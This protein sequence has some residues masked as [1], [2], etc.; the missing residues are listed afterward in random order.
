M[1]IEIR[2]RRFNPTNKNFSLKPGVIIQTRIVR[3]EI[4]E[5]LVVVC[6]FFR[7]RFNVQCHVSS[8]KY[9]TELHI[10]KLQQK[11]VNLLSFSR[12]ILTN[13]VIHFFRF[14]CSDLS[15]STF[16]HSINTSWQRF[17]LL[18]KIYF[19]IISYKLWHSSKNK[20]FI[21][22]HLKI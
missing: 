17:V 19:V 18:F 13:C 21:Y 6:T 20:L 7:Y 9:V 5:K 16:L 2:L 10:T 12:N 22:V 11:T 4:V 8:V 14:N 3:L 15:L 1:G